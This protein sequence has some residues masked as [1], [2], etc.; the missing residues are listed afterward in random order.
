[1]IHVGSGET[2]VRMRVLGEESLAPGTTGLVRFH[3]PVALP[4]LP[5]D[6]FIVRESGRSETV[7]GGEVLDVAPMRAASRAR[8]DSSMSTSLRPLPACGVHP[9]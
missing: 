8:P 1:V 5:G 2:P 7:G 9:T 3:L 4:L 6:R